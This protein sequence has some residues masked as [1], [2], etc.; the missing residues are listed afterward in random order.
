MVRLAGF[1]ELEGSHWQLSA[2]AAALHTPASTWNFTAKMFHLV[3]YMQTW[4]V[5][6]R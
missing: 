4:H 5:T 3:P 1:R 2:D 6:L